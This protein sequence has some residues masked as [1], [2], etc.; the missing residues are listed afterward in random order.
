[1]EKGGYL[2]DGVNLAIETGDVIEA[3]IASS[4]EMQEAWRES[5]GNLFDANDYFRE[6]SPAKHERLV[7]ESMDVGGAVLGIAAGAAIGMLGAP[8]ALGVALGVGAGI[9]I[10]GFT[11]WAKNSYSRS[12]GSIENSNVASYEQLVSFYHEDSGELAS[13]SSLKEFYGNADVAEETPDIT[14]MNGDEDNDAIL[15]NEMD[16]VLINGGDGD[17]NI[18]NY[19]SSNVTINGDSGSD[20]IGNLNSNNVSINGGTGNDIISNYSDNVTINTG[21]GDN[22]VTIY[23]SSNVKI[24]TGDGD[25]FIENV[26][27]DAENQTIQ[28]GAGEDVILN[29]GNNVTIDSGGGSD[30]VKSLGDKVKIN[31][32][33]GDNS[34]HAEGKYVSITAGDGSNSIE[35]NSFS[36]GLIQTGNGADYIE[37]IGNNNTINALGG[38]NIICNIGKSNRVSAAEGDDYIENIG[39]FNIIDLGSGDNY[40]EFFGNSNSIVSGNGADLIL[41]DEGSDN[42]ILSGK[43]NDLIGLKNNSKTV[44]KYTTGDGND[45]I[46]GFGATDSLDISGDYSSTKSGDDILYKIGEGSILLKT[47][48]AD[49]EI[50]FDESKSKWA[51]RLV[52]NALNNLLIGSTK[53]DTL[54]GSSGN[55]T[56]TGGK[57]KDLFIFGG[58]NDFI[59]DYEKKDKISSDLT[60]KNFAINGKNL[61]F[62]FD[63]KKSLT[64]QNGAGKAI[65]M[66]SAVHFYTTDGIIDGKGKSITLL[67]TTKKFTADSKIV[68]IDGSATGASELVGNKKKNLIYAG[69]NGSTLNGDKGKDTLVGGAGADVFIYNAGDGKDIIDDYGDGDLIS[70]NGAE[71]KDAKIKSGNSVIKIGSGSLTVKDTTEFT[72]MQDG[73]EKKFSAGVFV[74]EDTAKIYGSYNGAFNL[75]NYDVKNFDAS[76][77]KKKLTIT[78]TDSANSLVGG[79]GKDKIYGGDGSDTLTGGKGNDS[80]WGG[81]G[82]DTFI[83]GKGDG[84]DVIYNFDD[85]D[86]LQI[87]GTF[88]ASYNESKGEIA[89]KVGSTRNAITLKNFTATSFNINGDSYQISDSNFV[90]K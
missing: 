57:G 2:L 55:N 11:Q 88:S 69:T 37:N 22:T 70:L 49:D 18:D 17:D 13:Y 20:L 52:G 77:G 1:M 61:V 31:L 66:N 45:T 68:T 32:G 50:L 29:I 8:V 23:D 71:I 48:T 85:A 30:L 78:G 67:A 12:V 7:L 26:N 4:D 82:A 81:G 3:A 51:V 19:N 54:G 86:I 89:L 87:A 25:N 21:E 35:A 90:K 38:D 63:D 28:T 41:L 79:K 9:V 73:A 53:N 5:G 84:R 59:T 10:N 27:P 34:I 40:V 80:L 56:L 15:N 33:A 46:F 75:A 60:Y 62:N 76:Q 74:E 6:K 44:I 58:G 14:T 83:Y 43:G 42:T 36:Y 47:E 64:I 65:D 16:D 24:T 39:D 72:F